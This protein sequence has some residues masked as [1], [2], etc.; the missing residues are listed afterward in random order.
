MVSVGWIDDLLRAAASSGDDVATRAAIVVAK[1]AGYS[2]D[3]VDATLIAA[4]SASK[5][6][7]SITSGVLKFV[8]EHPYIT[9]AGVVGAG[10]TGIAAIGAAKG[11]ITGIELGATN[12][13]SGGTALPTAFVVDVAGKQKAQPTAPTDVAKD[14]GLFGWFTDSFMTGLFG[15]QETKEDLLTKLK[16][17]L[18]GGAVIVGIVAVGYTVK[19]F[20]K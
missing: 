12:L 2:D 16:P 4:K 5:T 20:K 8:G 11:M 18:V 17:W 15:T 9:T 14:T 19:A 3:I 7:G 10:L 6:T 13:L 1:N